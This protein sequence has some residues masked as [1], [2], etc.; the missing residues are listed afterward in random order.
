M[1]FVQAIPKIWKLDC[2]FKFIE[3]DDDTF[4]VP[5]ARAYFSRASNKPVNETCCNDVLQGG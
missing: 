3:D 4:N 2:L 1:S 5:G